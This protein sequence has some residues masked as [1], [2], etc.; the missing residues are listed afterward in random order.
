MTSQRRSASGFR[1]AITWSIVAVLVAAAAIAGTVWG[2]QGLDA[3]RRL[4]RD[5]QPAAGSSA[6]ASGSASEP[7]A[8]ASG[9]NS[10]SPTP[11]VTP[12]PVG[13]VGAASAAPGGKPVTAAQV[14]AAL[15]KIST[16]KLGS[17]SGYVIDLATG[18]PVYN[19]GGAAPLLPASTMKVLTCSS[20]L[21]ALGPWH[22]F[23]TTVVSPAAGQIV[24]VGG[25]DPLLASTQSK[26]Y[27]AR[28]TTAALAASTA[29]AL[30]AKGVSSVTLGYDDSLFTGPAWNPTWPA[31]YRDQ[32]SAISSLWVDEGKTTMAAG[33]SANPAAGA[34]TIFAAQL[35]ASG[36]TVAGRINRS[37]G[38][39]GATQVAS[40]S[41]LPVATLVQQ[42]LLHSDNNAA[43]VLLR[44]AALASGQPG[45]FVGGVTA[46]QAHLT[47]LGLWNA[48]AKLVDG[49]G[50]SRT[51][52]AT[53]SMLAGA[54]RV[55]A[56]NDQLRPLLD[57]LPVAGI[58]GTLQSRFYIDAALGG[59][60]VVHAK[61]GTLTHVS[62]FAGYTTTRSGR[63]LAF[64]F[65]VNGA[66]L[67]VPVNPKTAGTN[68]WG[69][70]NYL[71]TVT[72]VLAGL[73]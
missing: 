43:E 3:V 54:I 32:V 37:T 60:G 61:T 49:S 70:R 30:K 65:M 21:D 10:A 59:R 15:T 63:P 48:K 41:S 29:K 25:G 39:A 12:A 35:K 33:A 55:A 72:S 57:G 56:T 42:T 2:P 9:T 53:A 16:A 22:T 5:N 68:D 64:S 13:V 23:S 36:I 67:N 27:P 73:P 1:R 24:L 31:T 14:T 47:K 17:I 45:S 28:A 19:A 26:T 50:L 71:D 52:R 69:M 38:H 62:T 11:S 18:T 46:V 8:A 44:Q 51:D 40:V 20:A 7:S 58:T 66:A 6:S 34:A 4:V